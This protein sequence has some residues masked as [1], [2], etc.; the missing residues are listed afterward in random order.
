MNEEVALITAAG[1]N[2][3]AIQVI[4]QPMPRDEYVELGRALGDEMEV[5]GAEQAGFLI[6]HHHHF[7]MA[8]GEFCGNASRAAAILFSRI[9]G[10]SKVHFTVSGFEGVVTATVGKQSSDLYD[11]RCE[12]PGLPTDVQQ[13]ELADGEPASL[14]DLG[15]IVHVVINGEFPK[16]PAAYQA[17]HREIMDHFNLTQRDAVGVI[18]YHENDGVVTMHPVVWVRAVDTFFYENS[19]GSGTIAVGRVTG[20]SLITQPTGKVITVEIEEDTVSLESEMEVVPLVQYAT[21]TDDTPTDTQRDGFVRAYQEAFGGAPY[22]EHYTSEQVLEDVW[23]PHLHDGIVNLAL[24]TEGQVIG[25]G[26]ALPLAKSPVEIREFLKAQQQNGTF[27]VD[28]D[29]VWYMSELGVLEAYRRR[30][31]GYSL[32]KH[33]LRLISQ[34]GGTHYVFRTAAQG[35]NSIHLYRKLNA[36]E[37]PD[38]QDVSQT[39]QVTVNESHSTKRVYLYGDCAS[40]LQL[41][42][43]I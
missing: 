5:Y 9:E 18:W 26:C 42:T 23:Q 10:T 35:S 30:G 38:V 20:K 36:I 13:I 29:K 7:E 3:T 28:L 43:T 40:T 8:G 14:V 2:G 27:P 16:E 6:P 34:L 37:L 33:R 25:F 22:F 32:V 39:D 21:V 41:L 31:I 4:D 11:V 1:G 12:F 17:A 24:D 15:G 19:C